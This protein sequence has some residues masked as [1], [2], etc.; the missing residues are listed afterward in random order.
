MCDSVVADVEEVGG[1]EA[2]GA[3]AAA[4]SSDSASEPGSLSQLV[5]IGSV[6]VTDGL[7]V[8]GVDPLFFRLELRLTGAGV[9]DLPGGM[10]SSWLEPGRA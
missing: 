2:G 10:A 9:G 1:E 4:L 5:S 8:P 7:G 6:T 3:V